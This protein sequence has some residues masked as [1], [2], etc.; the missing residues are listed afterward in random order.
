M[1]RLDSPVV[2]SF[3][4]FEADVVRVAR[5]WPRVRSLVVGDVVSP[6]PAV[7][8]AKVRETL[9]EGKVAVVAHLDVVRVS[10][11]QE[12]VKRQVWRSPL[13]P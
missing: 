2:V 6:S 10:V 9:V 4:H 8:E 1:E 12:L 3:E 5:R 11:G 13:D 7:K